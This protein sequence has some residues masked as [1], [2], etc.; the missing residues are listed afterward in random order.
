MMAKMNSSLSKIE[1]I[2]S[3]LHNCSDADNCSKLILGTADD[4][5]QSLGGEEIMDKYKQN[6]TVSDPLFI[7]I[8]IAYMT[9]IFFGT[10]GNSLVVLAIA[11]NPHMRTP[12]NLLLMNLAFSDILLCIFTIPFTLIEILQK[13]WTLGEVMCHLVSAMQGVGIFVSSLTITAIAL[14]RYQ[15][16]IHA[17]KIRLKSPGVYAKILVIWISS[18]TMATPLV[19]FKKL[20]AVD[21]KIHDWET[22]KVDQN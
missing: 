3:M 7:S 19:M 5:I 11:R 6:Q 13:Y 15:L 21:A 12:S 16:I 22:V 4:I 14:D 10:T 2:F 20:D 8:V 17:R 18:I 1:A 9:V